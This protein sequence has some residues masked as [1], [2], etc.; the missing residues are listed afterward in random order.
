MDSASLS[1]H[2]MQRI[3]NDSRAIDTPFAMVN[4]EK[5]Y[6]HGYETPPPSAHDY[7][8]GSSFSAS[9][10]A[11]HG[12]VSSASSRPFTPDV[13][14]QDTLC[15][16]VGAWSSEHRSADLLQSHGVYNA[17]Y[18]HEPHQLVSAFR[19]VSTKQAL[20]S[21]EYD[22]NQMQHAYGPY[23]DGSVPLSG[24]AHHNQLSLPGIITHS[25]Q[26]LE[27]P[28]LG[29]ALFPTADQTYPTSATNSF[30]S[31]LSL[32]TGTASSASYGAV[33]NHSFDATL[34]HTLELALQSR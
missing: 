23:V 2:T 21:P 16:N 19:T 25:S 31:S 4:S 26:M 20:P 14:P 8:R 1:F 11:D 28:S 3:D 29:H 7:R 18:E 5:L 32:L 30:D 13:L 22:G 17:V 9:S 34:G 10:T 33:Y 12:L 6:N 15:C 27:G 24:Y